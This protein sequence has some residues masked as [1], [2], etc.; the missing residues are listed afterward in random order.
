MEF[1]NIIGIFYNLVSFNREI[2][3]FVE[4]Q[5]VESVVL[6]KLMI[7]EFVMFACIKQSM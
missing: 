3:E 1:L 6:A 5:Y 4:K 2:V 7:T